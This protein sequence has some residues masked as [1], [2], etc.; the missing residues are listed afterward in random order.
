MSLINEALKKV[1]Q[2]RSRSGGDALPGG[3]GGGGYGVS[4]AG[5]SEGFKWLFGG[6]IGLALLVFA[7]G[8]LLSVLREAPEGVEGSPVR[9]PSAQPDNGGTVKRSNLAH[10][11]VALR[12][13]AGPTAGDGPQ[14]EQA[15]PATRG[16]GIETVSVRL[17]QPVT[18]AGTDPAAEEPTRSAAESPSSTAP[19]PSEPAPTAS[20]SPAPEPEAGPKPEPE[21]GPAAS[22]PEASNPEPATAPP[23]PEPE[24]EPAPTLGPEE[25]DP[26]VLDFLDKSRLLGVR[27][28]GR[29]SKIL[30]N[31]QVFPLNATVDRRLQLRFVGLTQTEILFEDARGVRYTKRY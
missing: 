3:G 8:F 2:E 13:E 6:L 19:A 31:G 10:E 21:P 18:P 22:G 28:D 15:T 23:E 24:P 9:Q 30:L 29:K 26:A 17:V 25:R 27:N 12:E 20:A 1:Q 4:R 14:G 16:S 7:I 5:G 11:P